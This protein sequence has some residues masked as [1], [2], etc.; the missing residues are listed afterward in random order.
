[1]PER[2]EFDPRARLREIA[3]ALVR[4]RD[5]RL[6]MEYLRLRRAAR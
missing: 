3:T 4:T 1:M 2:R 5:R 6:L